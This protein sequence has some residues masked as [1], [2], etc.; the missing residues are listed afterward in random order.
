MFFDD[1]RPDR[2]KRAAR[3]QGGLYTPP[4]LAASPIPPAKSYELLAAEEILYGGD[5]T[6]I[7]DVESYVNYFEVGFKCDETNKVIYFEDSPEAEI[8]TMLLGF[9]LERF[10]L[11]GFNS[12][13][14][15]IIVLMIAR[16]GVKAPFLKEISNEI[17]QGG[18]QQYESEMRWGVKT[19]HLNHIDLIEVAP[20]QASLKAY[21]G[22]LHCHTMQDL[23]FPEY[24]EL[25]RDQSIIV[26]DYNINDLDN[27]QGLWR[28]LK[29]QIELREALGAEYNLDLRSKS[30][31][32]IAEAVIKSELEKIGVDTR[33][34]EKAS[35]QTFYYQVPDFIKFRTPMLQNVLATVAS[36]L[37]EVGESGKANCP[38][39][40]K[41]LKIAINQSTYQMGN[42]GLHSSEKSMAH[43]AT[44]DTLLIDR[45]VASYYPQIVL[46][47]GLYPEH[48]GPAFLEVYR[49]IVLRRLKAKREGNKVVSE[50][51]KITING[52]FG[53]L[54]SQYSRL[55]SSDLMSQVTV[56]GQL[57]L[58]MLI[59][60]VEL[61]GI[62]V[63]SANTD[64]IVIKC[65]AN[66]YHDLE[67]V[68]IAWEEQTGFTTE[69]T[70]YRGLFCRD[71]NNYIAVKKDNEGNCKT[72]GVYSEKGS[73]L[74]SVLSKNPENL[75]CSDAVQA[76]L[77][78]GVPIS[79][80]ILASR[81]IRRFV[82]VRTVKGGAMKA[83]VYLGKA[84]RWYYAKGETGEINY[85]LTGNKVPK[86]ECA[87]PLMILPNEF[88]AD[89]DFDRYIAEAT[90]MLYEI[91]Y[92]SK[93]KTG[94]LF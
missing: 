6:F 86:S 20:I 67:T 73:A 33:K 15:D 90:E 47:Q 83:G 77:A 88:P 13:K 87:K 41:S 69:E 66:R 19:G 12:R 54:G 71:V 11:V 53:K 44:P 35:G 61:I 85:V 82:S 42:G 14:Y 59:E 37:F 18:M 28:H 56:T 79:E 60:A 17:I 75:I 94:A 31:A 29:P 43:V 50:A 5:R 65:P 9:I 91:G 30:D 36:T 22:R 24:A 93:P 57:C 1:S 4:S 40:I 84:I 62:P 27:T 92:Y 80:T 38:D 58:L 21:S 45:D 46:N 3:G 68:V 78:R 10:R 55:Y 16:Q 64:G 74:N 89:L 81:D 25:T 23:P 2:R 34:P 48:L 7:F 76:F 39:A 70:Q 8:D 51:L 72:K 32:Q 26:R 49:S 52:A 63:V